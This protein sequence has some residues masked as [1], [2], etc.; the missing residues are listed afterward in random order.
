MT[1]SAPP[2]SKRTLWLAL[3][4]FPVFFGVFGVVFVLLLQV[5]PPPRPDVG[6]EYMTHYFET[7]RS[8][9]LIGL[10]LLCLVF[11]GHAV[12]NGFVTYHMKRMS[13]GSTFAYVYMGGLAVGTLPGMLL[14]AVCWG[15][16]AL[17]P[18]REPRIIGLLYDLGML[19]FNGSLG[20]FATAYLAFAIAILVDKSDIFPKWLAYL[21]IWQIVTEVIATQMW[22]QTSGPFAWNGSIAF[23]LAVIVFGVW[24]NCQF[25][26]LKKAT[27]EQ[28]AGS[29]P[30]D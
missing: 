2:A 6:F 29:R 13:S 30:H 7:H 23:W 26:M 21:T 12:A 8:T 9:I 20:C 10:G 1:L 11:G 3:W 27:E 24:L 17:R 18:E 19:S 15:T 4:I 5:I 16:A 14:V 22:Q 28:P 25:L